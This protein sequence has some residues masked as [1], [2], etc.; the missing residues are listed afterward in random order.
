[1]AFSCHSALKARF[2]Q[3]PLHCRCWL[4]R[5][6]VLSSEAASWGPLRRLFLKL[7]T[8]MYL[9]SCSAVQR[10]PPLPFLLWLEPICAVWREQY[11]PL[12]EILHF[13]TIS[14]LQHP[15]RS[16]PRTCDR[17]FLDHSLGLIFLDQVSWVNF[18]HKQNDSTSVNPLKKLVFPVQDTCCNKGQSVDVSFTV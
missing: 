4:W 6:R 9:S 11:P 16:T 2:P 7:E 5:L 14:P 13:L 15:Y 12:K 1:M 18:S 10:G 17:G 8:L 3:W